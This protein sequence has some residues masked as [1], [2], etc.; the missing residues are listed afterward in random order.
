[1][2]SKNSAPSPNLKKID[3]GRPPGAFANMKP[4]RKNSTSSTNSSLSCP[5]STRSDKKSLQT[6]PL[7]SGLE[8]RKR[9][10]KKSSVAF[11]LTDTSQES[12]SDGEDGMDLDDEDVDEGEADVEDNSAA[13]TDCCFKEELFSDDE[14]KEKLEDVKRGD[15]TELEKAISVEENADDIKDSF[16]SSVCKKND[17]PEEKLVLKKETSEEI[18][19]D[20]VPE[21]EHPVV[22]KV[23]KDTCEISF[24][25]GH[26]ISGSID[27]SIK[28]S[29]PV[30]E[31]EKKTIAVETPSN[32]VT[33]RTYSDIIKPAKII[34]P[35]V[36]SAS[37]DNK[38]DK[39]PVFSHILSN[40]LP[41]SSTSVADYMTK[42]I[43]ELSVPPLTEHKT[44]LS[45][46]GLHGLIQKSAFEKSVIP[47][48]GPPKICMVDSVDKVEPCIDSVPNSSNI[49]EKT[50][51]ESKSALDTLRPEKVT[52]VF[53]SSTMLSNS[54][55]C[56]SI[57]SEESYA[58]KNIGNIYSCIVKPDTA[59]VAPDNVKH[60]FEGDTNIKVIS[61]DKNS[62]VQKD[63][64]LKCPDNKTNLLETTNISA[65]KPSILSPA[66]L[67]AVNNDTFEKKSKDSFDLLAPGNNS[68]TQEQK[69]T[70]VKDNIFSLSF[71][72]SK[73]KF[74]L[75][76][77][78]NKLL[79]GENLCRIKPKPSETV[80]LSKTIPG[81]IERLKKDVVADL[82]IT[83]SPPPQK[84]ELNFD[85]LRGSQDPV[86]SLSRSD[87]SNSLR[88]CEDLSDTNDSNTDS[89]DLII[90]DKFDA[91]N[92]LPVSNSQNLLPV[93][94]EHS[95]DKISEVIYGSVT[96]VKADDTSSFTKKEDLNNSQKTS[97]I[98]VVTSSVTNETLPVTPEIKDIKK[99]ILQSEVT[100]V[101]S[102][103]DEHKTDVPVSE[104]DTLSKEEC[105]L[106]V[107]TALAM[108]NCENSLSVAE[109]GDKISEVSEAINDKVKIS[110]NVSE[111][112][113]SL[114][115]DLLKIR[116]SSSNFNHSSVIMRVPENPKIMP[117]NSG[118]LS[119]VEEEGNNK[120]EDLVLSNAVSDE[121]SFKEESCVH[122][123]RM[124]RVEKITLDKQ[125]DD[126][127]TTS[128]VS[129]NKSSS[130]DNVIPE[131]DVNFSHQSK[132][133]GKKKKLGKKLGKKVCGLDGYEK[134]EKD[135]KVRDGKSK[136]KKR[137]RLE[138]EEADKG[139]DCDLK[140]KSKKLKKNKN[141]KRFPKHDDQFAEYAKKME[142]KDDDHKDFTLD[143]MKRKEK[144]KSDKK[145]L[146]SGMKSD[147]FSDTKVELPKKK[148]GKKNRDKLGNDRKDFSEKKTKKKRKPHIEDNQDSDS[149]KE[150]VTKLIDKKKK[151]ERKKFKVKDCSSSDD[152]TDKFFKEQNKDLST[153]PIAADAVLRQDSKSDDPD[154][155]FLLCEEKVPASPVGISN[156][157]DD[158]SGSSS[159][160]GSRV[161]SEIERLPL[162]NVYPCIDNL[163]SSD[164][165]NKHNIDTSAVLDNTP[166]TTPS[167]TESLLSSSPSHER[168]SFSMNYPESTQSGRESC[169][170]ESEIYRCNSNRTVMRGSEEYRAATTL[171]FAVCKTV[172]E[173]PKDNISH[174]FLKRQKSET[175]DHTPSKRKKK[176]KRIRRCSES[177]KSPRHK[178]SLPRMSKVE[179]CCEDS[180]GASPATSNSPPYGST[181]TLS[182]TRSSPHRL[183]CVSDGMSRYNFY[184]PLHD[185]DPEKRIALL[186]EK[187]AEL[188]QQYMA[189]RAKVIAIDH[190]RRKAR[191]KVREAGAAVT[192]PAV[193]SEDGQSCS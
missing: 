80:D 70:L 49:E 12:E 114:F 181:S 39:S 44:T 192:N 91:S 179:S 16:F 173:K 191:K 127:L 182:F 134:E 68:F 123:E 167:S 159:I 13:P 170:G 62:D 48:K 54:Q 126:Y 85:F 45:F 172:N 117:S 36:S 140:S 47:E 11:G 52:S 67:S 81:I 177:A 89:K 187:M 146:K 168:D 153:V 98:T 101:A 18:K 72:A 46:A 109:V 22:P 63:E 107:D 125:K 21:I 71:S 166:P 34:F 150:T 99:D 128:T 165:I 183:S 136:S 163:E 100:A 23:E 76:Q 149:D 37:S 122:L 24:R 115:D 94:R 6:S 104:A 157:A 29:S 169:E 43:Y 86:K 124:D 162:P 105:K 137:V 138:N 83:D 151:K 25:M 58:C 118:E 74:M 148:K 116:N 154:M 60:S 113:D 90:N 97:V 132:K 84:E 112:K 131:D 110:S 1:M 184:V 32:P 143:K 82:K 40:P 160:D 133:E 164:T 174:V 129:E 180:S 33:K 106:T 79:A 5:R 31:I 119:P 190:K 152:A 111:N 77:P 3:R 51:T 66:K 96:S 15:I 175:D 28:L 130:D 55:T 19:L 20:I 30:L 155:S 103:C 53:S 73:D 57:K 193:Q 108:E 9:I 61:E 161:N 35:S 139:K 17:I 2:N 188:R 87:S 189:L 69:K 135:F 178:S 78:Y 7:S 102:K 4:A 156:I 8:P 145:F 93:V 147:E 185:K 92:A 65:V 88:I 158:T 59:K 26:G 14:E 10:R 64:K 75:D 171:A 38:L 42:N 56:E 27:T 121:F 186:Q 120:Q 141:K 95:P 41:T 50:N 142:S 144:R 176:S